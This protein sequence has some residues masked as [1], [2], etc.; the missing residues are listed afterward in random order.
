[1]SSNSALERTVNKVLTQTEQDL[2][3]KID[4]AYQESLT[5]L[6]KSKTNLRLEYDKIVQG[7]RKQAENLKRQIVGSSRLASRNK[8]LVIV[9]TA[10]NDAFEM[11]KK[12]LESSVKQK[13]YSILINKMLK[14][15]ISAIGSNEVIVECNKTDT[16]LVKK[17]IS[18]LSKDNIKAK[19]VLSEKSIDVI[20]GIRMRSSDGSMTY[21]NTLDSRIERLKP[22][23]RKNIVQMLR[24]EQ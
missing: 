9:E 11:A 12:E 5:N 13:S 22:L 1:M 19:V 24:G 2:I 4:S 20:G 17:S 3:T 8:Q 15:S 14:E 23:I 18:G 7:A 6:E 16:D 10:V 21:D